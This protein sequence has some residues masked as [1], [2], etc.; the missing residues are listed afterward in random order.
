MKKV[1]NVIFVIILIVSLVSFGFL[2]TGRAMLNTTTA[3]VKEDG[4]INGIGANY[5]IK[6]DRKT[7]TYAEIQNIDKI[8]LNIVH[9]YLDEDLKK[10]GIPTDTVEYVFKE[11][12]YEAMYYDYR[13]KAIGYLKGT[14]EKPELELDRINAMVEKGLTKYNQDHEEKLDVTKIKNEVNK[15]AKDIDTQI[16]K[17]K[18]NKTL[19]TALKLATSDMLFI[20][21]IILGIISMIILIIMNKLDGIKLTGIGTGIA[22]IILIIL[23]HLEGLSIFKKLSEVSGQLVKYIMS[24]IHDLGLIY[25]VIGVALVL[26]VTIIQNTKSKKEV[27]EESKTE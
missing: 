19:T 11:D 14:D 17:L 7:V 5:E 10:Q 15:V 8:D 16:E 6:G 20:G 9:Q 18:D 27:K 1:I 12:D 2:K 26:V 3:E 4:K 24:S 23:S 13:A 21:S 22:G 25:L